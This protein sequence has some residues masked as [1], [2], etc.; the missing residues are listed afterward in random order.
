MPSRSR[1]GVAAAGVL[2]LALVTTLT[3]CSPVGW[4]IAIGAAAVCAYAPSRWNHAYSTQYQPAAVTQMPTKRGD[5]RLGFLEADDRGWLRDTLQARVLLDSLQ[6]LH[7]RSNV[8]V[9][10]YAHG[11]RHNASPKDADVRSF[12]ATLRHLA[13]Q[14]DGPELAAQRAE[15]TQDPS[16]VV[17]GIYIGW[18]GKAWPELGKHV[19]YVGPLTLDLPVYFTTFSRKSTAHVVGRGDVRRFLLRLDDMHREINSRADKPNSQVRPLGLIVV[20]H[21]YG[22]HMVFDALG[23]RLEEAMSTAVSGHYTREPE[24]LSER[25]YPPQPLAPRDSCRRLIEGVGDLVVLVNPAIEA[26]TYRRIDGMVRSMKFRSD[27]APLL[28]TV[29]AEDDGARKTVFPVMRRV[30]HAGEASL[31]EQQQTLERAALG[32][33]SEQVTNELLLAEG[34]DANRERASRNVIDDDQDELEKAYGEYAPPLFGPAT[35]RDTCAARRLFQEQVIGLVRMRPTPGTPARTMPALVFRASR[36][37]V[38]G[39]SGFFR[40]EFVNWLT[41]Y[42]MQVEQARLDAYR[43]RR[44]GQVRDEEIARA[45]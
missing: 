42:V 14:L 30:Q 15:L 20:G 41:S 3:S 7:Q 29:S 18:R 35:G 19:P 38:A 40:I 32:I 8:V 17:Y 21:S 25:V 34:T 45:P 6:A 23:E 43:C 36:D 11:W 44:Q 26:S 16:M 28:I 31:G 10:V 4:G 13:R 27:Q 33:A 24:G 2:A 22:G 1:G 9:V 39:H 12:E 5:V 37:V